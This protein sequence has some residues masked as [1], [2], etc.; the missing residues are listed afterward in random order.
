M[1]IR[2][3]RTAPSPPL[4]PLLQKEIKDA[5]ELVLHGEEKTLVE[6]VETCIRYSPYGPFT[7]REVELLRAAAKQGSS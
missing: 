2:R 5:K 7:P 3:S 4:S 1:P 6:A